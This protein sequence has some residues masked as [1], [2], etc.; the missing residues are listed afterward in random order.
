[1][2][3]ATRATMSTPER[4]VRHAMYKLDGKHTTVACDGC[5]PPSGQSR[6]YKPRPSSCGGCHPD[7]AVHKGM[8][9]TFCERCHT[10]RGWR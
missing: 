2:P 7:P 6:L 5:H 10:T 4:S 3:A 1:M 8:H 9:G